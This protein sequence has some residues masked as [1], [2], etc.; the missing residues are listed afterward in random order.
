[1]GRRLWRIVLPLVVIAS[2]SGV[3]AWL[4]ATRPE[5]ARTQPE[6][7]VWPV[8]AVEVSAGDWQPRL[9]V[10]GQIVASRE[11]E[12]RA[13]VAGPV[14][15]VGEAY[16][17]GGIAREGDLL[18]AID[19]FDYQATLDERRAQYAEAEA[20]LDEYLVG[21]DIE[22]EALEQDIE[23]LQMYER[24][25]ARAEAL[26][27]AGN[28]SEKTLDSAAIA[29]SRHRQQVLMR[30]KTLDTFTAK[31]A[32]Q[33]AV[34]DQLDVAIRRAHRD[35]DRTRLAAPFDG[36][37]SETRAAI[38]QRL[39]VS[40]RVARL[41]VADELEVSIHIADAPYGR[42]LSEGPLAGRPAK[43]VWR[44]GT[45]VIS[46]DAV[47]ERVSA[48]IDPASGGV[49]VYARLVDAG[50]DSP[51]RPGAFVEI[52]LADRRYVDVVR[53]PESALHG[54]HVYAIVAG[55]LE[56]REVAVAARH[57]EEILVRG[58]IQAGE[59]ILTTRLTEIAPGL[60]VEIR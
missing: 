10:Y 19:P 26:R 55:R 57:G 35:L 48:R 24:D 5:L 32:Q 8:A 4:E 44:A 45:T 13:L 15:E 38:G 41:T 59:K 50:L 46:A 54:E 36:F 20:R 6:E 51:L 28:V 25:L 52:E 18:V 42:L 17:E 56:P 43:V 58:D 16:V 22:A 11:V 31:L 49:D 21:Q 3:F 39:G 40:D 1:M 33:A 27:P 12:M 9:K 29:L 23:Q 30:R 37:L 2:A 34:I 53:L 60:K 47:I 7:R 14:V